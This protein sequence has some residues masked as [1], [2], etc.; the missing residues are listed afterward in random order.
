MTA[1]QEKKPEPAALVVPEPSFSKRDATTPQPQATSL[2][3]ALAGAAADPRTDMDKMERLFAMHQTMLKQEAER[4]FNEAMACAQANLKPIATNAYND[5]TKSKYAKLAAI[6]DALTPIHTA[7]GL[8]VSFDAH[9]PEFDKDGKEINPPREGW[10]RTIAFVSH[11]AGHTRK[12]HLDLPLDAAGAKGNVNKTDVQAMGS[13]N[14]YARRYLKFMIFDVA[15]FDDDDGNGARS[16][17][18]GQL[19]EKEATDHLAAIDGAGKDDLMKVFGVAWN[20][21]EKVKDKGAQ[22]LFIQHRDARKAKLGIKS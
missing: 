7:E 18:G 11:K 2:V 1:V 8:S 3:Q 9:T 17:S 15:T 22:R 13:T 10:H 6:N 19:S 14:S 5:H 21:A 16:G 4:A 20:A 12:Y